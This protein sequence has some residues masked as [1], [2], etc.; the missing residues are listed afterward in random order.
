MDPVIVTT[1]ERRAAERQGGHLGRQRCVR[2]GSSAT[3]ICATP[4]SAA[5]VAQPE[6][7]RAL[8]LHATVAAPGGSASSARRPTTPRSGGRQGCAVRTDS[9]GVVYVVWEGT[10]TRPARASSTWPA[11]STAAATSTSPGRSPRC[12]TSGCFDPVSGR[13]VF[14]GFAG[15]RTDS[16]PSLSI[17]N[18]APTGAGATN[19][20]RAHLARRRAQPRAGTRADLDRRRPPGRRPSTPP[21]R[22]LTGRTTRPSRSRPPAATCTWFTTPT[23][24]R[25]RP[26]P[27]TRGEC[28]ASPATPTWRRRGAVG[29]VDL[30]PWGGRRRARYHQDAQPGGGLRLPVR[31]RDPR[32]RGSGLDGRPQRRRL[33]RG[34]RL[35]AVSDRRHP[36]AAPSPLTDCPAQFGN[37][38]IFGGVSLDP[39]P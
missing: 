10:D 17:A 36:I 1:P 22:A 33:P 32:L 14:D 13:I 18:G 7:D 25:S 3:S 11:R 19:T 21:R 38:D 20:H 26:L 31:R 24:S 30:A 5:S 15:T 4:P 34:G 28:R 27:P 8:G 6:P 12:T 29:L 37:D 16:F 9:A 2:A 39:T 35:P 23:C